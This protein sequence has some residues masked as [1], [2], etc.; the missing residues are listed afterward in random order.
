MPNM[1]KTSRYSRRHTHMSDLVD[2]E[3]LVI[4]ANK[5]KPYTVTL[6]AIKSRELPNPSE[7]MTESLEAELRHVPDLRPY[8]GD[9]DLVQRRLYHYDRKYFIYKCVEPT[10]RKLPRN[11]KLD[12]FKNARVYGDAFIFVVRKIWK[13]KERRKAD[14][15]E[16][17]EI[18]DFGKSLGA[19]KWEYAHRIL[20]K[21]ARM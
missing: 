3:V 20:D 7:V 17:R 18:E 14:F 11:Q 15:A 10:Q 1:V 2:V 6:N 12:I 9:I 19:D 8:Y 4:P 13:E 5:G 21:M 16:R